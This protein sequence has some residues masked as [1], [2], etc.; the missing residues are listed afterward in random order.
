MNRRL[1]SLLIF[2]GACAQ[3]LRSQRAEEGDPWVMLEV[4][5]TM[6]VS[7][8]LIK[9]DYTTGMCVKNITNHRSDNASNSMEEDSEMLHP[10]VIPS[11]ERAMSMHVESSVT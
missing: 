2:C 6:R 4:I 1:F 5:Y 10:L 9:V 7:W 3:L 11:S 8:V